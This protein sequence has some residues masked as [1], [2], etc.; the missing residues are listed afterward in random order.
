[1]PHFPA[2]RRAPWLRC[3]IAAPAP[4]PADAVALRTCRTDVRIRS[5]PSHRKDKCM[6]ISTLT[7]AAAVGLIGAPLAAQ[8][9][10]PVPPPVHQKAPAAH[11]PPAQ[12]KLPVVPAPPKSQDRADSTIASPPP[13]PR[14][15]FNRVDGGFVRLD[16]NTGQV[17]FCSAQAAGWACELVPEDRAALDKEITL[18]R[19]PPPLPA[20]LPPQSV[21]PSAAKNDEFS[22]NLHKDLARAR[23]YLKR[24][25]QRV[26]EMVG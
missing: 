13:P 17:A 25:W 24:T 10:L 3:G 11:A 19:A 22:R 4:P 16:N 20:P 8:Q 23:A 7:A 2:R 9:V 21:P 14:Y 12:E 6:R 18:L 1:M 5:M 26:V 15:A